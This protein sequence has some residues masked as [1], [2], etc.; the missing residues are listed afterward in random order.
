MTFSKILIANRGEI[1][2]RVIRTA[3]KLGYQTVAVYSD[4]DRDAPHVALADEAVH[5]GASP[6]S[7]S[8]LKFDTIL[9]AARKTGANALHPG[10]GFLSENAAFAQACVDAGVVFIGPPPSAITAMGDKA[11]AKK[12]ML[13][14]GVPCAPGYLGADQSD[15][16]LT[17]EAKKLGYPLLV[18]AVAGGGGRGMRLVRSDAELQQGIEG[19]RREATSAFGDGTLM[20]ERLIDNGRHI[21]IQVFADAH[22]NAVYLGERDC[23]AQ[24]RRQKV[25]E[26][27]PSPVVSPAMREAMGKDAVAAALAV[28]YRGAGTVEFIVDDKLNHYFLEMNTR[29]QV[30]HPVTECITGYDLVE[31]QLQ[32]A[33]GDPLPAKQSDIT[34]TGHAIE[35]RLYVEDPYSSFAPQTGTVAWW[36]P[37]RALV[38]GVRIDDGIREGSVV[39][40]FYDPMVAKIIV[41]GRDRDDAIRRLRA[42]LANTPLLGLKNN[43]RV[44][45]DLVD[46]PAFRKAEMTT[47]LIDQWLEQ[48]EPLLQ[49]PVASDAAWQVTAVALA[50][51]QG[52]SWR[53]NSV[54]AYGFKLQ[55]ADAMRAVR[56]QPDRHGVVAVTIDGVNAQAKVI[57]FEDGILRL[58]LNGVVQ[59]AIAVF[60]GAALHLA[61]AGHTHQFT[62]VSAFP[63]ADALKDASRARS[64]VAGKVTQV[65]VAPGAAVENGQQLVCV[66]AMKMEMWLCAES[67]GTV[68][69]VHA[70]AGD[71]VESGALLVE[72]EINKDA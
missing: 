65:L 16:A 35:A 37:E 42:A 28:G 47:T 14:A 53:A 68:K 17:A 39:S 67:A 6:A 12:R 46:H 31:W 57:R 71:Q 36:Q 32:V 41:H 29:L 8:Y 58:E 69:A 19:A 4:A 63:N 52:N 56:V 10:Y 60:V 44:L 11:L 9:D 23:T 55:C 20:L 34:L 18:K 45:S 43:G 5:I 70:I 50:M 1:A 30:E 38:G 48:G 25:I 64:P 54:A 2:C 72:L 51:Q 40:P 49:A 22:G 61:Y 26:E 27:A 13:E 62:E 7:E 66:E 3:R 21:E 24:R 15:A 59:T 33:A